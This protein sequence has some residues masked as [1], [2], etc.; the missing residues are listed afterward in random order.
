MGQK[1]DP[2]VLVGMY[3]Q[4]KQQPENVGKTPDD[5]Q[6]MVLSYGTNPA[7]FHDRTYQG[8]GYA[9][10]RD[11]KMWADFKVMAQVQDDLGVAGGGNR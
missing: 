4:W 3:K 5:F 1:V 8:Q 9:Y 11:K 2:Q 10:S 7:R 6:T